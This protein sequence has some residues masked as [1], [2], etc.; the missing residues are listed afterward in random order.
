MKILDIYDI[1]LA[2]LRA[3][4]EDMIKSSGGT[5]TLGHLPLTRRAERILRNAYNEAA[6]LGASAP[7]TNIYCWRC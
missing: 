2:D 1:D 6:A 7:M 5:M 4:I 3:M